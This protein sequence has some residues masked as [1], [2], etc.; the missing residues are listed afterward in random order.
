MNKVEYKFYMDQRVTTPFGDSGIIEMLGYDDG[1]VKYYVKTKADS[2]W[3]KEDEL[4]A[5]RN[6]LTEG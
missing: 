3:F 1:G 4:T 6:W 2:G 5:S